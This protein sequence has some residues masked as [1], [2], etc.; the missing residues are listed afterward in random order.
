MLRFPRSGYDRGTISALAPELDSWI[1]QDRLARS[2]RFG[3]GFVRMVLE[4]R[5]AETV[6]FVG[7]KMLYDHLY[8]IEN[9]AR[10]L[11]DVEKRGTLFIHVRRQDLLA[12][13]IIR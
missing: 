9:V 6:Q 11:T 4:G 5:Y 13:N 2:F 10:L 3:N 1:T 12:R 7:M 8:Q